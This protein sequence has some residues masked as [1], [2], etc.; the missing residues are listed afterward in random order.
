MPVT[1][2]HGTEHIDRHHLP[3]FALAGSTNFANGVT[4]LVYVRG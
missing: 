4:R 1:L 2:G 3:G